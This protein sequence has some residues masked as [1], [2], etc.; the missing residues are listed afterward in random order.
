MTTQEHPI[1]G[2]FVDG[3]DFP[4]VNERAIRASA[5]LLF[6]GGI[7][8]F[9]VAALTDEY[10]P[11]VMFGAIFIFDIT[12]RLFVGTKYTPSLVVGSLLVRAQRPAWVG[13]AQK[14][15]AWSLEER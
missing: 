11:L 6:F 7:I 1:I 5:G 3:V 12:F 9:M 4:V 2:G 14:K 8:D 13:A 15:L 10:Q